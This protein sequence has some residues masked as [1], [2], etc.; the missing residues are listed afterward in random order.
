M[1]K[2]IISIS[3]F[4]V[5]FSLSFILFSPSSICKEVENKTL[6]VDDDFDNSTIGWGNTT[7]NKIQDAINQGSAGD[8]IS[9]Y[10]GIYYEQI[11]IDKFINING[12]EN[13]IIEYR[14][15]YTFKNS[16]AVSI[17]VNNVSFSNFIVKY[18]SSYD[19]SIGDIG[20]FINADNVKLVD[21]DISYF[22]DYGVEIRGNI[23]SIL[24]SNIFKN[25]NKGVYLYNSTNNKILSND[26]YDNYY[27]GI[28][29]EKSSNYN[30]I[31]NNNISGHVKG[32]HYSFDSSN[33]EIIENIFSNNIVDIYNES[34]NVLFL[35]FGAFFL[36]LIIGITLAVS[37][38]WKRNK[39]VKR[40]VGITLIFIWILFGIAFGILS[41]MFNPFPVSLK[42]SAYG[43][44]FL[45]YFSLISI[46]LY[47]IAIGLFKG[48]KWA[49]FA[50]LIM[51]IFNLV[52]AVFYGIDILSLI[53]ALIIIFYL[54]RPWVRKYFF[55]I[56][57]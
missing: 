18:N 1:F 38:F 11:K 32:I 12:S 54:T 29:L 37:F 10:D 4:F 28:F 20:I 26:I 24:N 43:S 14:K 45:L 53:I 30:M 7:F 52:N 33:N 2:K 23:N 8:N 17:Y 48:V 5:V 35:V 49:W 47:L 41:I 21:C 13:S 25:G 34:D 22:R 3:F 19:F 44:N 27:S 36:V 55:F 6:F 15:N 16:N 56:S 40:P 57:I 46:I 39:P 42:Y 51:W 9:V 50:A 31:K